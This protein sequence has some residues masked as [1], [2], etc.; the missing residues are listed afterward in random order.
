MNFVLETPSPGLKEQGDLSEPKV[1][2]TSR[3]A[4]AEFCKKVQQ[5][6]QEV[7]FCWT[8]SDE[9]EEFWALGTLLE[10]PMQ[11]SLE[12]EASFGPSASVLIRLFDESVDRSLVGVVY[13]GR[14]DPRPQSATQDW[15]NW[16]PGFVRI[17][18]F[19]CVRDT[20]TGN[21][22]VTEFSFWAE[23]E[24]SSTLQKVLDEA[25]GQRGHEYEPGTGT[26]N[27]RE[28]ETEDSWQSRVLKAAQSCHG[29]RLDKVVLARR[30]TGLVPSYCRLSPTLSYE[31]LCSAYPSATVFSVAKDGEVFMGATPERLATVR[32]GKLRTHAVAGTLPIGEESGQE[33]FEPKLLQEHEHVVVRLRN[34][35]SPMLDSLSMARKPEKLLAG[36]VA[37]LETK[38]SGRLSP[39]SNIMNVIDALHPTPALA[40]SPVRASLDYL[41]ETEALCRGYYGGPVGWMSVNGDGACAVAIRSGWFSADRKKVQAYAGA[42]IVPDSNPQ[43]EWDE[44]EAKLHAFIQQVRMIKAVTP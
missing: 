42:G 12:G 34:V 39:S 25:H 14:F 43:A 15:S 24:S 13:A 33:L 10:L 22:F 40:G 11:P 32:D 26:V 36:P 41:R 23:E 9:E 8:A 35:L 4:S 5:A 27:W 7:G 1:F 28:E 17:P 37:H 30:V 38:V 19:V 20:V 2:A 44:T 31:A 3:V 6:A 18:R 16:P 21:A 29:E